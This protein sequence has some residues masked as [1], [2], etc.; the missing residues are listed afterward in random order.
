MRPPLRNFAMILLCCPMSQLAGFKAKDQT[1]NSH[2][3]AHSWLCFGV[4]NSGICVGS[5]IRRC[6]APSGGEYDKSI[7]IKENAAPLGGMGSGMSGCKIKTGLKS[8]ETLSIGA[9]T[10][11]RSARSVC[12]VLLRL[13]L[14][15]G[16]RAL[17]IAYPE[18]A[19]A[20]TC[21]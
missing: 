5:I 15:R 16:G 13:T 6:R 19:R 3:K 7:V 9:L 18:Q 14:S 11:G 8:H 20:R 4:E 1:A 12:S 10:R 2:T 21:V 17:M